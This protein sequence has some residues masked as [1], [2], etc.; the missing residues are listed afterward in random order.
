MAWFRGK[1]ATVII[2]SQLVFILIIGLFGKYSREAGADKDASVT[3]DEE[4]SINR[5]YGVFQDVNVMV[6]VGFGFLMTFLKKYGYGAVGFTFL[7]ATFAIEWSTIV[8]GLIF[9]LKGGKFE[10]GVESLIE[11]DFSAAVVLISFGAILGKSSPLQLII[12]AIVEVV[13]SVGNEYLGLEIFEVTDVGGS[14]FIHAFGAYFGLGVAWI[15][16]RDA[17][18]NN[19]KEGATYNS[20][21]SAMIGTLFL[22]MFWPSFNGALVENELRHR[23]VINTYFSLAACCIVTFAI[24]SLSNKEGK[25]EMVA[26]QNAT[27]AGGVAVGTSADLLINPWGAITVGSIAAIVSTLGFKYCTPFL[28]DK[29]KLHD[30]CGVHNLH[31]MPGILGGVVGAIAATFATFETYGDSLVVQFPELGSTPSPRTAGSQAGYQIL[32]LAVTLA[33]SLVG[34]L[35]TGLIMKLKIW[36]EPSDRDLFSDYPFWDEVEAGHEDDGGN[37]VNMTEIS[38][39]ASAAAE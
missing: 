20:D 27:L 3:H 17:N 39:A 37:G 8:R 18:E 14:M 15:L 23:A 32:A 1:F 38:K 35:V 7:V 11:A 16:Q 25:I 10:I 9:N 26:I 2:I 34:G 24:S 12:M 13:L 33:I 5:Y 30:T 4:N 29:L 31:G 36:D 21:L 22:W 6:F 19:E 28:C